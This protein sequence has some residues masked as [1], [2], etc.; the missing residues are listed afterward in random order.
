MGASLRENGDMVYVTNKA[1]S[2]QLTALCNAQKPWQ[3]HSKE[4]ISKD[5]KIWRKR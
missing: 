1:S 4:D 3:L 5:F 2:K